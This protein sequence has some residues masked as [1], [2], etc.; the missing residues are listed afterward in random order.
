[1]K[2][3]LLIIKIIILLLKSIFYYFKSKMMADS[4]SSLKSNFES[5]TKVSLQK[6]STNYSTMNLSSNQ[7]NDPIITSSLLLN[8]QNKSNQVITSSLSQ[9]EST[10]SSLMR[11]STNVL[12]PDTSALSATHK[13]DIKNSLM[14]QITLTSE[15][16]SILDYITTF[17]P[18]NSYSIKSCNMMILGSAGTGKSYIIEQIQKLLNEYHQNTLIASHQAIAASNIEG[19]TLYKLF[20]FFNERII[21]YIHCDQHKYKFTKDNNTYTLAKRDYLFCHDPSRHFVTPPE[22]NWL[23]I[24]EISM[25]SLEV[26]NDLNLLLQN[27]FDN[28]SVFGNINVIFLGDFYQLKPV[29]ETPL[30]YLTKDHFIHYFKLFNLTIPQ[31]QKDPI[32][33]ELCQSIKKGILTSTQKKLLKSRLISNIT[34]SDKIDFQNIIHLFPLQKTCHSHNLNMLEKLSFE[35]LYIIVSTD[36]YHKDKSDFKLSP[37]DRESFNGLPRLSI[38][39]NQARIMIT[40]NDSKQ[41]IFNGLMGNVH[42]IS[43]LNPEHSEK[44]NYSIENKNYF[45]QTYNLSI[46]D[47]QFIN[48]LSQK[49]SSHN[50]KIVFSEE[51]T[52]SVILDKYKTIQ[53]LQPTLRQI[54]YTRVEKKSKDKSSKTIVIFSRR[55]IT[56]KLSYAATTHKMQGITL[57]S[58]VLYL[59]SDNF[60]P[61]QL[62]INISRVKDFN[63]VYLSDLKLPFQKN[64][65]KKKIKTFLNT[66]IENNSQNKQFLTQEP[67]FSLETFSDEIIDF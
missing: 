32:S 53:T 24:D 36:T 47:I 67:T 25:I 23:I 63:N 35:D 5:N 66:I 3:Y 31:R 15:Q 51:I 64:L 27:V 33:F 19:I 57:D 61:V 62:Y 45:I 41:N 37:S 6:N 4:P 48:S 16:Q 56:L 8:D 38:I 55:T 1:M 20:G 39:T 18:N 52:V 54:E 2:N 44:H 34:D 42:E 30:Y 17:L 29:K 11:N 49:F 26:L 14:T 59:G 50:I 13:D 60:D 22:K 65:D 46:D 58:A 43:L 40:C 10:S 12:S 28:T 7:E 9:D 21:S